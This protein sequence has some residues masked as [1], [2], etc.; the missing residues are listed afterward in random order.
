MSKPGERSAGPYRK[1]RNT[2]C[3][4]AMG[5]FMN[6]GRNRLFCNL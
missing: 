6:H 4:L 2:G 3:P 5:R 1:P